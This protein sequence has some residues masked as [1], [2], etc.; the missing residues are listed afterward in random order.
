MLLYKK[1]VFKHSTKLKGQTMAYPKLDVVRG[2]FWRIQNQR[3]RLMSEFIKDTISQ[4]IP[5]EIYVDS[6]PGVVLAWQ[7]W[8][9]LGFPKG[10]SELTHVA[11]DTSPISTMWS[12]GEGL[13]I[14]Y[15]NIVEPSRM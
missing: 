8:K 15:S 9:Q 7:L 1:A 12:K 4:G 6:E 14:K 3:F 13:S 2:S 5:V 10:S 11:I